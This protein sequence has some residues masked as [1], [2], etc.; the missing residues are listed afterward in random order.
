MGCA[1]GDFLFFKEITK[2]KIKYEKVKI[3]CSTSFF[4][5]SIYPPAARQDSQPSLNQV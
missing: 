4:T 2:K 3:F 1:T 5:N